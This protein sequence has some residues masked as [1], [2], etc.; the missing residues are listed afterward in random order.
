M[1]RAVLG[2]AVGLLA[3]T[4][5]MV[6]LSPEDAPPV[7]YHSLERD[8]VR[9]T[10]LGEKLTGQG[11]V[12]LQSMRAGEPEA[13]GMCRGFLADAGAWSRPLDEVGRRLAALDTRL[14]DD[15][16]VAVGAS[17]GQAIETLAA[18]AAVIAR[19]GEQVEQVDA[20]MSQTAQ[21]A[22]IAATRKGI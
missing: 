9:V 18:L 5:T 10:L 13:V 19:L 8:I 7:A 16:L 12:C 4:V 17:G 1:I 14:G 20:W 22:E 3:L 11:D 2:A 21:A 6:T 15:V